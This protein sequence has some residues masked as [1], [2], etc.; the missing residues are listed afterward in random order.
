LTPGTWTNPIVLG[1]ITLTIVVGNKSRGP[2][3][4]CCPPLP[5]NALSHHAITFQ[6]LKM[7]TNI[8]C[9]LS[10]ITASSLRKYP[11]PTF[12]RFQFLLCCL[13]SNHSDVS[14]PSDVQHSISRV[15]NNSTFG[16]TVTSPQ[17]TTRHESVMSV[18]CSGE[19]RKFFSGFSTNSVED[20]GQRERRS[21]GGSP[22]VRG[23]T[24]FANE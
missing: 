6:T 23:S 13:F 15:T 10:A 7:S 20:R 22:L 8:F 4:C 18:Y 16:N 12:G 17:K 2:L 24:Q 5:V 21:G 14:V 19:T 3:S 9:I 1:L 11:S